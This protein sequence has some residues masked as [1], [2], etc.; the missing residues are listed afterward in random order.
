MPLHS[1][2]LDRGREPQCE[3]NSAYPLGMDIDVS[4]G[5]VA[6][7]SMALPYPAKRCGLHVVRCSD[8]TASVAITTAG[9]IDDARSI[10]LACRLQDVTKQ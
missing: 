2:W 8:C 6:T 1:E 4:R 5:A 10:K 9:R 7:C 3:P